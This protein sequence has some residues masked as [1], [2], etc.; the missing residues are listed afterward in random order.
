M[1]GAS[2]VILENERSRG[3]LPAG[4]SRDLS[5]S[6]SVLVVSADPT[7]RGDMIKILRECGLN[8][9][10]AQ[11]L[12][13]LRELPLRESVVACL[14]GFALSDGT[15]REVSDH[16]KN[17]PTEIPMIMVSAPA[18][19]REY[20][21]FLESLSVGAFDFICHPYRLNDIELILWSAIQSFCE[22]AQFH[23]QQVSQLNDSAE[24]LPLRGF[25][26]RSFA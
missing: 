20:G 23:P 7:L 4:P 8:G 16:L 11:G 24:V 18:P 25:W 22:S 10:P 3:I 14:C 15:V 17:Q 1:K 6:R 26:L 19:I 2:T 9:I 5:R 21:D 12:A 13:E